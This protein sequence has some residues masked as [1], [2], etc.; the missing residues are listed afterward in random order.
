MFLI[1]KVFYFTSTFPFVKQG[2]EGTS[3][4]YLELPHPNI[5]IVAVC[6]S[7]WEPFVHT[8]C[9]GVVSDGGD[10]DVKSAT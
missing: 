2:V 4:N 1:K 7:S 8:H 9:W 10:P 6:I 5:T 3:K